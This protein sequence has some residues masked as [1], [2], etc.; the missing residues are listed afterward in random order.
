MLRLADRLPRDRW[1]LEV[2]VSLLSHA[3]VRKQVIS[4]ATTLSVT[5]T[6]FALAEDPKTVLHPRGN[7]HEVAEQQ[8]L[9]ANDLA[10]SNMSRDMLVT[11]AGDVDRDFAAIMIAHRQAAID[12]AQAEL[13]YGRDEGLRG[14][15][16]SIVDESEREI[17]ALRSRQT[18]LTA[19]AAEDLA[20]N[21][22][23]QAIPGEKQ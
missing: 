17:S 3:L 11:P 9:F 18:T 16:R 23:R 22:A 10:I 12:L 7:A 13:K 20:A 14:L 1:S 6:S 15:A 8:F 4:L 5:A 21:N 2:A 19:Q